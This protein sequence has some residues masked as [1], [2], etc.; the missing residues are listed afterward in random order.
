MNR[1]TPGEF[2][3]LGLAGEIAGWDRRD[4]DALG[5]AKG[6]GQVSSHGWSRVTRRS[7]RNGGRADGVR[8]GIGVPKAETGAKG[9][10]ARVPLLAAR[11]GPHGKVF[12]GDAGAWG[13]ISAK[14]LD[15]TA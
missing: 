8:G 15:G 2:A 3:D 5:G 9:G 1:S 12:D 6:G 13:A 7:G 4:G 11:F 14:H 10:F